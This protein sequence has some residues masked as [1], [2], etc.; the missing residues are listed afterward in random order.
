MLGIAMKC[1]KRRNMKNFMVL[2]WHRSGFTLIE[3]VVVLILLGV[4]SAVALSRYSNVGSPSTSDIE[5]L[6]SSTRQAQMRA[7]GDIA[8]ANWKI[9]VS[10]SSVSI[11]NGASVV[12][13]TSL[14]D[15]TIAFTIVF[16]NRG[17]VSSSTGT[18]PFGVDA[19]TGF[20]K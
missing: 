6:K 1:N 20:I 12:V 5:T 11:Q 17:R 15:S 19:E 3:L 13:T 9:I 8:S 10:N 16:D 4:I 14:N 18:I 2:S 7:M